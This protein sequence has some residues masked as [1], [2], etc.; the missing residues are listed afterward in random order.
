MSCNASGTYGSRLV[1]NGTTHLAIG[2]KAADKVVLL[3]LAEHG[4]PSLPEV[5]APK[6]WLP[7]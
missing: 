7:A 5:A 3:P 1:Q 2:R 6:G 4:V